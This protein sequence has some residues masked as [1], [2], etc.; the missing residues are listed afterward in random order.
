VDRNTTTT[1]TG[2]KH[3][4]NSGQKHNDNNNRTDN[5]MSDSLF[6]LVGDG[7]LLV[8]A[9]QTT[10]RS[11]FILK[12][13]HDK[14]LELDSHKLL[15]CS[16]DDGDRTYFTEYIQKNVH[17]YSY[18]TGI[19]LDTKSA[20]HFTR[21]ELATALRSNP[22]FTNLLLG[23]Y[24]KVQNQN[25]KQQQQP[26]PAP[27]EADTLELEEEEEKGEFSLYFIDYLASMHKVPFASHGYAAYFVYGI[28]DK[29]Y[30]PDMNLEEGIKLIRLCVEE[31]QKRFLLQQPHFM[32][33]ILDKNGV[34]QIPL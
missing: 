4:D 26:P 32:V 34:R 14:I 8:A 28:L 18:R 25:Q 13:D 21:G 20:A 17:L 19:K 16:G 22:Y 9:D 5:T 23:G 31:V 15:G 33:K 11:I 27:Q 29:Y 10:A 3:N 12:R 30:R 7:Y 2:Q 6:G 24:D 1:T